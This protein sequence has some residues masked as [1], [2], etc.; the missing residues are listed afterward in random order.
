MKSERE[1]EGAKHVEQMEQLSAAHSKEVAKLKQEM[2]WVSA[3][4]DQRLEEALT[5]QKLQFDVK[6]NETTSKVSRS[7]KD[8]MLYLLFA[9][10]L[11]MLFS[12]LEF[13]ALKARDRERELQ[14]AARLERDKMQDAVKA[15]RVELLSYK[16]RS[17]NVASVS[18]ARCLTSESS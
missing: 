6:L 8:L 18:I 4:W 3:E 1:L 11:P 10:V 9:S 16:V 5:A 7:G 2:K 15:A 17:L 13:V 14:I 12:L